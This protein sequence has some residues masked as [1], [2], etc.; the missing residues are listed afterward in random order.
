MPEQPPPLLTPWALIALVILLAVILLAV[1]MLLSR[2]F[3]R[4][5]KPPHR[6]GGPDPWLESGRRIE[7]D[8]HGD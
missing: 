2:R 6:Q 3:R 4:A 5:N 7:T 8:H 1:T